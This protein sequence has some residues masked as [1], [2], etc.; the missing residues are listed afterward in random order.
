[1]AE[2]E[3]ENA[4]LKGAA[5]RRS[6]VLQQSRSFITSYLEVRGC[7]KAVWTAATGQASPCGHP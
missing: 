5:Q 1:M 3:N 6:T 2:L 4:A 7:A